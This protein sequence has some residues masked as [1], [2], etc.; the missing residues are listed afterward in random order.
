MWRAA[1]KTHC[2]VE[3]VR[4]VLARGVPAGAVLLITF[5]NKAARELRERV[6]GA[7]AVRPSTFHAFCLA[8]C[9]RARLVPRA[10]SI[11]YAYA[12]A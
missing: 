3:R 9:R 2:L 5:T 6:A 11:W 8:L 7:G 4:Q 1:G 12:H 10:C